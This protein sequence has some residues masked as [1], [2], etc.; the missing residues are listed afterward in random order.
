MMMDMSQIYLAFNFGPL[1]LDFIFESTSVE[2]DAT[3]AQRSTT[4]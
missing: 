3:L 2:W 4:Q 1:E